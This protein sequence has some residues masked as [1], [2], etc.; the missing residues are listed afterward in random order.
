MLLS[1]RLHP[2]TV[3]ILPASFLSSVS[4]AVFFMVQ[5]ASASHEV[6]VID[7]E[8]VIPSVS[9]TSD[10]NITVPPLPTFSSASKKEP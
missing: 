3:N 9:E 6:I 1:I 7:F 2:V 8:T 4:F 5:G 10:R